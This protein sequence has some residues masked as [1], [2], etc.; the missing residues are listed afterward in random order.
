[1]TFT[2][3][4]W[5]LVWGGM[6]TS[7][8]HLQSPTFPADAFELFQGLRALCPFLAIFL[9]L[10]WLIKERSRFLFM[11]DP[12]G[13]FFG[14]G[15]LGAVVSVI[16]SPQP[17]VSLYWAG[18]FLA[19]FFVLWLISGT[20][21]YERRIHLLMYVNDAV[22][23]IL[24]LS[25]LPSAIRIFRGRAMY[26]VLYDLPFGLGQVTRNG[27]GRYAL[28]VI[29]FSSVRMIAETRRWKWLWAVPL[30]PAFFLLAQT[31][32][33]TALLGL[34]VSVGFFILIKGIDWRFF[35]VGPAAAFVVWTSGFQWRAHGQMDVLLSLSGRET[36]WQAGLSQ[37]QRS[38][39]FGWGFN[40]DRILLNQEHIHNSYLQALIQTG[41]VGAILFLAAFLGLGYLIF[42]KNIIPHTRR[43]S[44]KR[45]TM[46]LEAL[47][48]VGFLF[49]RSFFEA[50]AAFYGVDLLV[51]VPAMALL[52]YTSGRHDETEGAGQ[53]L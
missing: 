48:I 39:I 33:R 49:S 11:R 10:M 37:V 18:V 4:L 34:V 45:Q 38:P 23:F 30:G 47:L 13:F 6:F 31:Q 36:T 1:M 17:S 19:P 16:L 14:Y 53:R 2:L 9:S 27:V 12:L 5:L 25:M 29:I 15:V 26:S 35:F 41:L 44:G 8:H 52:S 3:V 50:T 46:L 42:R 28:I 7:I 22:F 51:L 21:D 32:S 24:T 40:A 43:L 20:G